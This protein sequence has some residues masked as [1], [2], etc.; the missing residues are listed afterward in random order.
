MDAVGDTLRPAEINMGDALEPSRK[1]RK[2]KLAN[3]RK[4]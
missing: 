2:M 3:E 4:Q 1:K